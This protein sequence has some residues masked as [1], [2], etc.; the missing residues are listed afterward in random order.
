MTTEQ[1]VE[2]LERTNRRY[3]WG[4]AIVIFAAMI[5]G[6]AGAGD[7]VPDVIRA[8]KFEVVTQWGTP[9][10]VMESWKLGGRSGNGG[11]ETFSAKGTPLVTL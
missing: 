7:D 10:V 2:R 3:R 11:V 5:A 1:R 6:A 4:I 8:R 9:V